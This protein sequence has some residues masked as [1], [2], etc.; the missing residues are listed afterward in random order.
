M[1]TKLSYYLPVLR[2][3]WVGDL[4]YVSINSIKTFTGYK[5]TSYFR[6]PPRLQSLMVRVPHWWCFYRNKLKAPME[7]E[8]NLLF[9]A[10]WT[11]SDSLFNSKNSRK[12]L[13]GWCWLL[14]TICKEVAHLSSRPSRHGHDVK[15]SWSDDIVVFFTVSTTFVTFGWWRISC[16]QLLKSTPT[17]T[18]W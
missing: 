9:Q 17:L 14:V 7:T 13:V 5:S 4:Q 1:G 16:C 11:I 8:H 6:P 2:K 10:F 15:I 3:N 18:G 12:E